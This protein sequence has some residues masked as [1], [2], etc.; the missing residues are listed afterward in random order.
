M[1]STLSPDQQLLF[2]SCYEVWPGRKDRGPAEKAW[3]GL[4][5]DKEDAAWMRDYIIKLAA[6]YRQRPD[7]LKY[8]GGFAPFLNQKKYRNEIDKQGDNAR[9]PQPI[10]QCAEC[11]EPS[12]SLNHSRCAYHESMRA[13]SSS[14]LRDA[15]RHL[16]K[17]YGKNCDWRDLYSRLRKGE[18]V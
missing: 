17:K 16:V 2:D 14:W 4:K 6:H 13:E 18:R 9:K 1:K 15:Y 10:R 5:F 12:F 7:E 3:K 8:L 11:S